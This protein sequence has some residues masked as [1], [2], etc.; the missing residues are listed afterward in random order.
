MTPVTAGSYSKEDRERA[1]AI[2][3]EQDTNYANLTT[4]DF[5]RE[6]WAEHGLLVTK[7]MC[8]KRAFLV[9]MSQKVFQ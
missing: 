4:E 7:K 6:A 9:L 5:S 1:L 3:A 2:F 8:K